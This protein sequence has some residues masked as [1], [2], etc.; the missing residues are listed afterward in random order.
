MKKRKKGQKFGRETAQRRAL[1]ISLARSLFL[2]GKIETTLSKA[3]EAGRFGEK[4]ITKAKK[5]DLSA[6][7]H[8]LKSFD[9]EVT[10]K[11]IDEIAVRYADRMGGYTR[12]T[13]LGPRQSDGAE[14]AV[15]EL[16]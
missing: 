11:L 10:S 8:L 14:I 12:V 6:R 4:C 15:V 2:N 1:R 5:G 13:K 7:R 9:T 16:V 3:K